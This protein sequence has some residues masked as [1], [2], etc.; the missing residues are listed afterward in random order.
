MNLGI[1]LHDTI[2]Y[3]PEFFKTLLKDWPFKRYIVTGTPESQRNETI[4]IL[5]SYGVTREYYDEVIS[6]FEYKKSEMN[7][8]HF[9][10]MREHKLQVIKEYDIKIFFDDNPFYV[11][12]LKDNTT[13][14][15]VILSSEYLERF[16]EKDPFFTCNFQAD[17]FEYL[18]KLTDSKIKKTLNN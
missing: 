6:G 14:F 5:N 16:K 15:Q 11:D 2:S 8:S 7:L 18:E 13:V 12:Y 17:Q 3:R 1:D 9:K 10:H 4:E